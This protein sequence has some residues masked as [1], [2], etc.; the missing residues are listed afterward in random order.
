MYFRVSN[1]PV[2]ILILNIFYTF[3]AIIST[4]IEYNVSARMA[5][6]YNLIEFNIINIELKHTFLSKL[7]K[8]H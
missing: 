3:H 1:V 2:Y 7:Q 5:T 4:N 8:K 6:L